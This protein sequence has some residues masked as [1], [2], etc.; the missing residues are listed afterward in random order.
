MFR[1]IRYRV[2]SG[3]MAAVMAAVQTVS[4]LPASAADTDPGLTYQSIELF[5]NGRLADQVVTLDGMMPEGASVR[6]VDVSDDF[7]GAAAYDITIK[8]GRVD[9]QPGVDHPILVEIADPVITDNITLWHIHDD[10]AREQMF[11]VKA[12]TGKVSFYATGFSVYEIVNETVGFDVTETVVPVSGSTAAFDTYTLVPAGEYTSFSYPVVEKVYP[13]IYGTATQITTPEAFTANLA[14]GLYIRSYDTHASYAMNSMSNISASRRG[15]AVTSQFKSTD[16][17]KNM[18]DAYNAGAAKYYF[19]EESTGLYYIYTYDAGGTKQYVGWEEPNANSR[20]LYLTDDKNNTDHPAH[21]W[22]VNFSGNQVYIKD[23]KTNHYW[24]SKYDNENSKGF[25]NYTLNGA[26]EKFTLWQYE[27]PVFETDPYDLD[28]HTYGLVSASQKRAMLSGIPSNYAGRIGNVTVDAVTDPDTGAVTSYTSVYYALSG[29]EFEWISGTVTYKLSTLAEDGAVKKYLQMTDVLGLVD[30]ADASVFA[31]VPDENGRIKLVSGSSTLQAENNYFSRGDN[32]E[33]QNKY[34]VLVDLTAPDDPAGLDGKTVGLVNKTTNLYNAVLAAVDTVNASALDNQVLEVRTSDG[35]ETELYFPG[36]ISEW[37]FR[38]IDA[39]RYTISNGSKYLKIVNEQVTLSDDPYILTVV[40]GEGTNEGRIRITSPTNKRQMRRAN[41]SFVYDSYTNYNADRWF[42]LV[43]VP[44]SPAAD[45]LGLDGQSYGIMNRNSATTGS[46]MMAQAMS[47]TTLERLGAAFDSAALQYQTQGVPS[48]WT[49]HWTGEYANYTISVTQS[50]GTEKWLKFDFDGLSLVGAADAVPVTVA[51]SDSYPGQVRI[52]PYH[53]TGVGSL[54]RTGTSFAKKQQVNTAQASF[55]H[56][57]VTFEEED[58]YNL[59]GKTYGLLYST[60]G[61]VGYALQADSDQH[62]AQLDSIVTRDASEIKTYY[63]YQD[64]D[65][66]LWTFESTG[67]DR[68]RLKSDTGQYLALEDGALSLVS[69]ASDAAAFQVKPQSDSSICL[70]SGNNCI[71]FDGTGFSVSE[72]ASPLHLVKKTDVTDEDYITY[73]AKRISVSDGQEAC[74][75]QQ[76]IVYTRVWD[77]VNKRYDFYAIDHDGSLKAVYAYG[78]KIMWLDDAVQTLWWKLTVYTNPDGS[79]TG[80]YELQNTYSG[81]YLAPLLTDGRTLSDTKV[82]IEMPGRIFETV[83]QTDPVTGAETVTYNYG[84]YYSPII[85]WDKRYYDYAGL[86]AVITDAGKRTGEIQS[87]SYAL[88][89]TFYFA[90]PDDV[91]ANEQEA[92]L[93]PVTT[94]DNNEYGIT[95]R[96]IDFGV[97]PGFTSPNANASTVTQ[98]YFG[99]D[100]D[101]TPGLLSESLDENGNPTVAK[102]RNDEQIGTSFGNAFSTATEVNH[103][104]IQSIHDSSGYFEFDSTQNYATLLNADG[105]VS[106]VFTVYRELGS[107]DSSTKNTLRHGQFF[108]YNTIVPGLYD[109]ANAN[110]GYNLYN[111]DATTADSTTHP[112]GLLPDYDPR[113]YEKLYKINNPDYYFGMEMEAQFVQ[114]PNGLDA[115]G[116]DIIFEFTGDDDFWLYVDGELVIDLGGIHSAEAGSVNFRTGKVI[117]NGVQTT[118]KEIFTQ[119]YQHKSF[120]EDEAKAKILR[121]DCGADRDITLAEYQQLYEDEYNAA[122]A[123]YLT[124]NPNAMDVDVE[125]YLTEQLT[126]RNITY[127]EYVALHP[128]ERD[129]DALIASYMAQL[130]DDEQTAFYINNMFEH[131]GETGANAGYV[132]KDYT[133]HEMK[134]YYMERGAGASNLHMRFNLSAVTPGNVLFAKQLSGVDSSS[135]M[136]LGLVQYPFQIFWKYSENDSWNP[137]LN[138]DSANHL[139]VRYQ[140]STQTVKFAEEYIPPSEAGKDDPI[141]Y[142]NVFF[143]VPGRSIEINFPDNAMYYMVKEC[144]VN[145]DI[146][147]TVSAT[148]ADG[149]TLPLET[150]EV[151]GNIKDLITGAAQVQM[152]PTIAFD[153]RVKEGG[154]RSLNITKY[155]YDEND[156]GSCDHANRL[157]YADDPTTFT[158]RLYLTNGTSDELQAANLQRYY[159]LDE[160]GS[161]CTWDSETQ[162]FGRLMIGVKSYAAVNAAGLASVTFEELPAPLPEG[163]QGNAIPGSDDCYVTDS[164]GYV[165]MFDTESNE[166]ARYQQA[167]GD[168]SALSEAEKQK[169]TFHTSQYGTISNIPAG[170]TVKVPGLVAGT[171]FVVEERD[172]EIPVGYG[173]INFEPGYETIDGTAGQ[174]SYL[175]D[176]PDHVNHG[177]ISSKSDAHLLVNNQRGFGIRANKIWSDSDFTSAHGTIYTAV[178]IGDSETPEPGTVKTIKSDESSVQYFF[179]S[180]QPGKTIA[181]YHIYEVVWAPVTDGN[182][183]P[184][185]DEH[186]DPVYAYQKLKQGSKLEDLSVTDLDGNKMTDDY[187]VSYATGTP[188]KT[189]EVFTAENARTDTIRNTRKGGL[190]ITLNVWN[191]SID[192]DDTPLEGGTFRLTLIRD[193]HETVVGTFVSDADGTV[194]VL[195][196]FEAG[197]RYKLEE[198]ISP[199]GYLGVVEPIFFSVSEDNNIYYLDEWNNPNDLGADE[200]MIRPGV[201]RDDK[202]WAECDLTDD[203]LIAKINLYNKPFTLKVLKADSEDPTHVLSGAHFE[204]YKSVFSSVAGTIKDF[205]PLAGYEDLVT[206]DDGVIPGIDQTLLPRTYYLTETH[207]PNNYTKL[208]ED[209][210]FEMMDNGEIICSDEYM[211]RQETTVD[212]ALHVTF[213][214]SIPNTLE[215][216]SYYFDIEKLIFVDPY[217]H[218]EDRTQQFVFK[219]ERFADQ[220]AYQAGSVSDLFY[221]SMNCTEELGNTYPYDDLV[222]DIRHAYDEDTHEVSVSYGSGQ[223]YTF[224]TNIWQGRR[225]VRVGEAGIYRVSE[226]TEWSSTDYDYWGGSN[227]FSG[228]GEP[229]RYG[230]DDGYIVFDVGKVKADKFDRATAEIDGVTVGRPTASFTN[231][232]SEYAY[233]SAQAYA[234]NRLMRKAS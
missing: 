192:G 102:S 199:S 141:R 93:H 175:I 174:V 170:Y 104:F 214:I 127:E 7:E 10:G 5:P 210:I 216:S 168:P 94:I 204:L 115:W 4:V 131:N 156:D 124:E 145:T 212:G 70:I 230:H 227:I 130:H 117:V 143:L 177:T 173:L 233:L 203:I 140:N 207:A 45:P 107:H 72:T 139:N 222:A 1:Q 79:E 33:N 96:M 39:N 29:W 36:G 22:S 206:G 46:A 84:E 95:M 209:I 178:F 31:V 28:G 205:N 158:Y 27:P 3:I 165:C 185:L 182:G 113:K 67:A 193:G 183:D 73:T 171:Q 118:L 80:Y 9:Y 69:S 91:F 108:P 50:D 187:T 197:D 58:P 149:S 34:F 232:E 191:T 16:A 90:I 136:D 196:N 21:I 159:V 61:S 44:A 63:V 66:T 8:D 132:F 19:E 48:V 195:Y 106:D 112:Q 97:A 221:V 51:V 157:S 59:D 23:S 164:A 99:G 211:T 88:A 82:G 150:K 54:E 148:G 77:D 163:Y 135:D 225:T 119:H 226:V 154:I 35:G 71:T 219:V 83:K 60:S 220:T 37:T 78:D 142:D 65:I 100:A 190:S 200:D 147:D 18:F 213:T 15:L 114:T 55:W 224:P 126:R 56:D 24:T 49:F 186:G 160:S 42:D 179:R 62:F 40:A 20:S 138:R 172:Y 121:V 43:T 162:R 6:A 134:I 198:T 76:V 26:G 85:A 2:F 189:N 120:T 98:D 30:A 103:L 128:T 151:S 125:D 155:L 64:D 17:N 41:D 38:N 181:D 166:Y 217:I 202:N 208:T 11:I 123:E 234:G 57:L 228:Y 153:N 109:D 87:S 129:Y 161:L 184:V 52:I 92:Q 105:E 89:D 101:N 218:S 13:S 116:H 25:A 215:V 81:K 47:A 133:T 188:V 137:L 53:D 32:R 180:L 152:Q 74:D 14:D 176:D 110:G 201:P 229:I 144:A 12:E 111:F 231:T 122:K 146:Y 167:T 194:T 86:N 75:G 223:T 68:Y 169:V